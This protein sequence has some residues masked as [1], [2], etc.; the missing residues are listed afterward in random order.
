MTLERLK[1]SMELDGWCV[2]KNIIPQD[3]LNDLRNQIITSTNL[4]RSPE[5]PK[6]IGHVSGFLK[7]DQS[8]GSFLTDRLVLNLVETLLGPHFRIS[9]TTATINEPG[10]VSYTHLPLPTRDLV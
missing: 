8:L 1:L 9:F 6:N 2:L 10:T 5:A 4:N 7:Y 3:R